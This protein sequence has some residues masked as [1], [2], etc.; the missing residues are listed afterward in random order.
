[1]QGMEDEI[2]RLS[3]ELERIQ[4]IGELEKKT[5]EQLEIQVTELKEKLSGKN[6]QTELEKNLEIGELNKKIKELQL[7][8]DEAD[9]SYKKKMEDSKNEQ[10]VKCQ[11]RSNFS[12]Q[13]CTFYF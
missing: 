8:L 3:S 12:F 7:L 11:T 6:V 10:G 1:M 9:K 5:N 4:D 2:N 13:L